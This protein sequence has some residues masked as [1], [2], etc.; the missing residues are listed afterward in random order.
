VRVVARE[1]DRAVGLHHVQ[2]LEQLARVVRLLDRLRR[3]AEVV[4]HGPA[5]ALG[6]PRD[7]A[8]E[9]LPV[10]VEPPQDVR[11][12]REPA[13]DEGEPQLRV[14]DEH[15]LADEADEVRLER[16]AA[17]RVPLHVEGGPAHRGRRPHDA[18]A[19]E[20]H[21]DD[22]AV[23]L[24]RLPHRVVEALPVGRAR[25]ARDERLD[26]VRVRAD[27]LDLGDRP[28]DAL[29]RQDHR[30]LE[31]RV[32]AQPVL[33]QPVVRR[34]R[35]RLGEVDV[36]HE[37]QVVERPG[38]DRR[39]DPVLVQVVAHHVAVRARGRAV[40]GLH[41]VARALLADDRRVHRLG[42]GQRPVA[43]GLDVRDP[44]LGHVRQ[45]VADRPGRVVHVA[46][47]DAP[48]RPGLAYLR[49]ALLHM[50]HVGP[51]SKVTARLVGRAYITA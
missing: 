15:A 34:A 7:L 26:D 42:P 5:G 27:P 45:E 47:D 2:D 49:L 33:D 1:Q 35:E 13:L 14:A 17:G 40:G 36:R 51:S 12:P 11:Q 3:E 8:A 32:V 25:S 6:Q 18:G 19:A 10:L 38:E 20:V 37:R 44:A 39:R 31:A 21:A 28:G 41:V 46:V 4:E 30:A 50:V 16:Q 43:R 22:E 9:R 48:R 29:Q 23:A 24:A